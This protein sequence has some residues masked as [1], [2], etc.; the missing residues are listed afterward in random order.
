MSS[1]FSF[2]FPVLLKKMR[3]D[4]TI[5]KTDFPIR[6]RCHELCVRHFQLWRIC[7]PSIQNT[8]VHSF[9]C[10]F[11]FLLEDPE[12]FEVWRVWLCPINFCISSTYNYV[13]SSQCYI[14]LKLTYS[15]LVGFFCCFVFCLFF[16][17]Q[18]PFW[19]GSAHILLVGKYCKYWCWLAVQKVSNGCICFSQYTCS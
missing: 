19:W 6:A 1:G 12:S 2:F 7:S 17:G 3:P 4:L 18:H 9:A 14:Q 16:N 8:S 10:V 5:L 11:E 13:H 15:F